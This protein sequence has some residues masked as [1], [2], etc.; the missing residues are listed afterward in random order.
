MCNW[1]VRQILKYDK[2]KVFLFAS[3]KNNFI[4]DVEIDNISANSVVL[5]NSKKI[6]TKS[7][8][9]F[10]ILKELSFPIK[11]LSMFRLLPL[12]ITDWFY[13]FIAHHRHT[14]FSFKENCTINAQAYKDR[15]YM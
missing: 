2:K 5:I 6:Y 14:I 15:I 8:A 13:D 4:N 3:F 12:S 9:V 11:I 7:R 1:A 10:N